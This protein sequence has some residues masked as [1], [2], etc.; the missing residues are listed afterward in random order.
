MNRTGM[1]P[2]SLEGDYDSAR[3]Q[4][5]MV[6]ELLELVRYRDLVRQLVARNIKIRYKRSV[7]GVAWS[8]LSP[9][10]TM[11]VLSVVFTTLFRSAAPHYML[12]LFPGLLVWN[13]F[14]Q[15]TSMMAAEI[16][17][18]AE[19]W[20]RIY[21]P[22]TVFAVATVTTGLVHFAL[23]M[24]PLAALLLIFRPPLGLSLLIL[25]LVVV[26][27]AMFSLGV[28]L[29]VSALAHYFADVVDLYQVILTAWM[30]C[31]PV[32]YPRSIVAARYQW[33]FGLNPMTYFVESFR[34]PL[35]ANAVPSAQFLVTGL[36][37]AVATLAA[38]WWLFTRTVDGSPWRG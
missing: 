36:T 20:K 5:P 2:V 37:M 12:Y 22:R 7:L 3:R 35:Y 10:L 11:A 21:M 6:R 24:V 28:G 17:G 32:I 38:G 19:V 9:L 4:S 34:A 8:L 13:L 16:I 30:Y 31:T 27:A 14:G 18:G 26:Q 33:L 1:A 29:A 25:P 23:A 15:T